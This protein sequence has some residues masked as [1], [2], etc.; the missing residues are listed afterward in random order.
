MSVGYL[1]KCSSRGRPKKSHPTQ[2]A[3]EAHRSALI[4]AGRW[5]AATSNTYFCGQCGGYHAG[6][7]GTANRG[8]GKKPAK[9]A[10]RHLASQ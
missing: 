7:T 8:G 2:A 10:P 1:A 5:R 9:N 4:A 6:S 3:A